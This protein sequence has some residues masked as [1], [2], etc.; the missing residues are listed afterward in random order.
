MS[1]IIIGLEFES[2]PIT[3]LTVN[4][5]PAFLATEIGGIL[6]LS[7]ARRTIRE[8]KVLEEG[9]D[10]DL[11]PTNLLGNPS[12]FQIRP[13]N[14]SGQNSETAVTSVANAPRGVVLILYPSGLFLF[15]IRSNKPLAIPFTRWVIREAIPFALRETQPQ[16]IDYSPKEVIH[17]MALE[18]KGSE[19]AKA[20]L[21]R[22]GLVA[23]QEQLALPQLA[24]GAQ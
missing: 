18:A 16:G 22:L 24:G 9:L 21:K 11:I 23:D 17:L 1:A 3:L 4:N 8:S 12:K 20:E 15:V 14:F 6:G 10:Y 2:N 5:Q 13:E 7:D 19:F